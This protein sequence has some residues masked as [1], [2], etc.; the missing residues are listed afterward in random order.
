[1]AVSS[2]NGAVVIVT[3]VRDN[4]GTRAAV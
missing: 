3:L 1:V 2:T 4:A